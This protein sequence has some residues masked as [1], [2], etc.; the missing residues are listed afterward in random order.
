MPQHRARRAPHLHGFPP[1]KTGLGSEPRWLYTEPALPSV[2]CRWV[3]REGGGSGSS[4]GTT[5]PS[6][7]PH[8]ARLR[9]PAPA[10]G[11]VPGAKFVRRSAAGTSRDE[12]GR[13]PAMPQ[14]PAPVTRG[15]LRPAGTRSQACGGAPGRL[16]GAH[17]RSPTPFSASPQRPVPP[18]RARPLLTASFSSAGGSRR[19]PSLRRRRPPRAGPNGALTAAA[20]G[21]AP[22]PPPLGF[23]AAS[24]SS[25]CPSAAAPPRLAGAERGGRTTSAPRRARGTARRGL[26]Q[27]REPLPPPPSLPGSGSPLPSRLLSSPLAFP[28]SPPALFAPTP[29]QPEA[30]RQ[31]RLSSARSCLALPQKRPAGSRTRT[32]PWSCPRPYP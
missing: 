30:G 20:F 22:P 4:T 11:P 5:S 6:L 29:G 32:W 27:Q 19:L 9:V 23:P 31:E 8:S 10:S 7:S 3:R 1:K 13:A 15:P 18:H 16:P 17:G 21:S 24:S 2:P 14:P 12:P 26:Q 25:S 28:L